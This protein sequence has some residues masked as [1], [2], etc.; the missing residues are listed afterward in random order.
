MLSF[1]TQLHTVVRETAEEAWR[2]ANALIKYVDD[3]AMDF[4]RVLLP[5]SSPSGSGTWRICTTAGA[6]S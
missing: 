5:A 3:E 6:T 1:E 2:E 4:L